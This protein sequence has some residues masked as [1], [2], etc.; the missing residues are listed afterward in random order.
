MESTLAGLAY[1]MLFVLG[2]VVGAVGAFTQAWPTGVLPLAA[3]AWVLAIFG[4]SWAAGRMTGR[5]LGAALLSGGWLLTTLLFVA[6]PATGDFV[7]F[8]T[9]GAVYLYGGMAAVVA[10]F[11]M[12][13]AS[14]TSW[15]LRGVERKPAPRA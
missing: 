9:A 6:Q 10:A 8:G 15:L 13:P 7:F 12:T 2:V 1:G 5:R 11:L 14:A 3:I 4:L